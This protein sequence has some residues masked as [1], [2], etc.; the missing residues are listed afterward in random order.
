MTVRTRQQRDPRREAG[1]LLEDVAR[2]YTRRMDISR[3]HRRFGRCDLADAWLA[4]AQEIVNCV[5]VSEVSSAWRN[6]EPALA[7][8]ER[9]P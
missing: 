3:R 5:R 2:A 9:R 1:D 6:A 8:L 4:A 7:D